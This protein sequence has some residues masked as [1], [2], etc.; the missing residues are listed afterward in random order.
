MTPLYFN[1]KAKKHGSRDGFYSFCKK[2]RNGNRR[3]ARAKNLGHYKAYMQEWKQRPEVVERERPRKEALAKAAERKA[4][5]KLVKARKAKLKKKAVKNPSKI[6]GKMRP[7]VVDIF[8]N[9]K[10]R[11]CGEWKQNTE[12]NYAMR[13]DYAKPSLDRICRKC[14]RE[15][16]KKNSNK[17]IRYNSNIYKNLSQYEDTRQDP[18]NKDLGQCRCAYCGRWVSPTYG[19]AKARVAS[20]NAWGFGEN[21]IYCEGDQCREACPTYKQQMYPKGF[22]QNSSRE[23][24]PAIRIMCLERDNWTCQR[25]GADD[26]DTTLHVHHILSYK[27]NIMLANDIENVITLCRD[28]HN[29]IHKTEGCQ[30]HELRCGAE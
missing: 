10:C 8:G 30:Y 13:N 12:D 9:K 17:R 26:P 1:K 3:A 28:C 7:A 19:A 11:K 4:E 21:R 2:C 18:E 22:K 16:G 6:K 15:F 24:D 27:R 20:F 23:V 5:R 29:E 25:C 14:R